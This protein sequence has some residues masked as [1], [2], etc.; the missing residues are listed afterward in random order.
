MKL[1]TLYAAAASY[2][3]PF[4]TTL[5]RRLS[6]ARRT[7]GALVGIAALAGMGVLV[8]LSAGP[9]LTTNALQNDT[10]Q[11]NLTSHVAGNGNTTDVTS[12]PTAPNS[13]T[14]G[15]GKVNLAGP[16]GATIDPT[17]TDTPPAGGQQQATPT[18]TPIVPTATD[19]PPPPPAP[20]ATTIPPTATP[21]GPSYHLIGRYSG[22]GPKHLATLYNVTGPIR[23]TWTCQLPDPTKTWQIMFMATN[24]AQ[25][26]SGQGYGT[27]CSGTTHY[28]GVII[29]DPEST[30]NGYGADFTLD[31]TQASGPWTATVEQWY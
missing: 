2:A 20:T 25:S 11:R 28:G 7:A 18:D 5:T 21:A 8:L 16:N 13:G 23:I 24:T 1:R 27:A 31:C 3:R 30:S 12:S 19:T 4:A 14:G 17:A 15:N 29:L 9:G 26:S 10:T 22:T 6:G